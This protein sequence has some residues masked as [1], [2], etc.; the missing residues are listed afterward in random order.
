MEL[1]LIV[2]IDS[3]PKIRA[4]C[5]MDYF[6]DLKINLKGKVIIKTDNEGITSHR[7][8]HY[9]KYGLLILKGLSLDFLL[10]NLPQV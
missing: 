2:T 9:I 5:Q 6:S 7:K 1:Q 3:K 10:Q 8:E 4:Y